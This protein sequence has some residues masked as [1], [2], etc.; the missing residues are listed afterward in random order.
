MPPG[1]VLFI[2]CAPSPCGPPLTVSRLAGR[3]PGDYYGHSVAIG[4]A[5]LRRSHV[6][7][8]YTYQRDLGV[9]SVSFNALTGHRSCTPEDY[10]RDLRTPRQGPVPVSCVFPAG[11]DSCLLETRLQAMRLSP[12]RADLPARRPVRIGNG[13]RFPGMLFS[14]ITFR[15]TGKPSD[16]KTPPPVHARS[17]GYIAVRLVAHTDHPDMDVH[18][19][20]TEWRYRAVVHL[21]AS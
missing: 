6:H 9:P 15:I 12:Y 11:S 7:N 13:R 1:L 17:A 20:R 8:C 3:H 10:H 5:S 14:P 21:G 2:A 16:P 18:C 4:L 19:C